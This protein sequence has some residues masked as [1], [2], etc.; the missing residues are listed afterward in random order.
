MPPRPVE[1]W[2]GSR[3]AL[4]YGAAAPQNA[5]PVPPPGADTDVGR[6]DESCLFLN[7]WTP[8]LDDA[9]RPVMVWIHGGAFILGSG[10]EP[11]SHGANL[12]ARGNV[13][14]VSINYRL[15]A[16]GF[17]NLKEAT[18][19][20][21]PATGNEGML[22]QVAALEW[23]R[24][25]IAA[26]GGNPANITVF[27]FSA[28]GMS[29]GVLMGMPAARGK[30]HKGINQSGAANT[31]GS[32]ERAVQ[33]SREYLKVLGLT[34]RDTEKLRALTW[35]K[36]L[37]AQEELRIRLRESEHV[38]T[39]FQPVVDGE[40]IPEFPIEA[41]RKG[42]AK[43]V[44]TLA[45]TVLDEWRGLSV[46]EPGIMDIS[47]DE[48]VSRLSDF[49]GRERVPGLVRTYREARKKR[50]AG[51]SPFDILCAVQT[52]LMF[53]IPTIQLVEAQ[54]DNG[55]PAYNYIFTY[56][57]PSMAGSTGPATDWTGVSFSGP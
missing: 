21:I 54:R 28:G 11:S 16:F 18:G 49:L 56:A 13:V 7:I 2:P 55:Q 15:G 31:V 20:R 8:G 44:I 50:G 33:M 25:N 24:D 37:A 30:F 41:I 47:E 39:P 45:G 48:V 19:G 5:M 52:D 53:R 1:P 29:I 23:V 42:S 46:G 26:F 43:G 36:L 4:K 27:G 34:G 38:I 32:L 10:N 57:R 6:Q 17:M 3:P 9:R 51:T 22:D 12:A 35:R 40:V 14:V